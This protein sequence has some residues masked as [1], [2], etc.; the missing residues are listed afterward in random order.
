VSPTGW[1]ETSGEEAG[2]LA[3]GTDGAQ[4]AGAYPI[5][6]ATTRGWPLAERLEQSAREI[7][8][9]WKEI[10]G[11]TAADRVAGQEAALRGEDVPPASEPGLRAELE[12]ANRVREAL[13][14]GLR[15]SADRLLEA[16]QPKAGELAAELEQ[17]LGSE[18]EAI[19]ARMVDLR[20]GLAELGQLYA[21]AMWTRALVDASGSTV[22]AFRAG[23]G[24]FTETDG[25]LSTVEQ[26]FAH[27]LSS[28][29]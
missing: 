26:A 19:R 3:S 11:A 7:A 21:Q 14:A 16:V 2:G 13:E 5:A 29:G 18:T 22:S 20:D 15:R 23:R 24:E 9:L 10:D 1:I 17:E 25:A 8:R 27:E 4:G 28:P 12:E 6:A